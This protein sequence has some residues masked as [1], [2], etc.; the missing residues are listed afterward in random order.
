MDDGRTDVGKHRIICPI[1]W[2]TDKSFKCRAKY[3][4]ND[5]AGICGRPRHWYVKGARATS[6]KKERRKKEERKGRN[7]L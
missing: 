4:E 2:A 7:L 1:R 5:A 6:K 3:F